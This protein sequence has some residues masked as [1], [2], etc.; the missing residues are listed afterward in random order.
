[1]SI[2]KLFGKSFLMKTD[3]NK[4]YLLHAVNNVTYFT[5]LSQS[6]LFCLK[7]GYVAKNEIAV[8]SN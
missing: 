4:E 8:I 1:M 6:F 2:V 3:H 5:C 7:M